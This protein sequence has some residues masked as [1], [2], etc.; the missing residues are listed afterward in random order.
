MGGVW[1]RQISTVRKVLNSTMKDQVLNDEQLDTLFCEAESVV[2]SRP[3]TPVS[4]DHKDNEPLTPNHLLTLRAG[5][6][7]PPGKFSKNDI[8]GKR[9]RHVQHLAD[10]FWRRWV[11]EY[12]PILQLRQKW[13]E[14]KPNLQVN[15][16]VL[17]MDENSPRRAWPLARIIRVFTGRDGLVRSAQVKTRWSV[18][19][20]PVHK[21]CVLEG[22]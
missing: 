19:T 2:N 15:D 18:L 7:G 9:W 17:I 16:I 5:Q 1:E 3:I 20:R 12:L 10:Y 11:R 13:L 4:S 21:L 14:P 8:Y 6:K 22:V